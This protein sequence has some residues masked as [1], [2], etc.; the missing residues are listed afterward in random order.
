MTPK[1]CLAHI[2]RGFDIPSLPDDRARASF[3]AALQ[4]RCTKKWRELKSERR[5]GLGFELM[6]KRQL[7]A[8]IPEQFQDQER[9]MVF[10]YH[11]RLPMAGVRILD[12]FHVVWLEPS[13]GD[14]YDHGS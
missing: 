8:P 11:G 5:H 12:T 4:V 3:A 6:P 14:L 10:R 2:Q 7:R 1:F 9:F 13:Y